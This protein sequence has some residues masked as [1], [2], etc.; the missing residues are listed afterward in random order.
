MGKIQAYHVYGKMRKLHK[1]FVKQSEEEGQL[2]L[3]KLRLNGKIIKTFII[4]G[5]KICIGHS[6]QRFL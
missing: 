1:S 5:V 3:K 6:W 2:K 4:Q